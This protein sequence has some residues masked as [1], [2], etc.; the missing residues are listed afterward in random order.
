[1]AVQF[2]FQ[3]SVENLIMENE[4]I[5]EYVADDNHTFTIYL[6]DQRLQLSYFHEIDEEPVCI[7]IMWHSVRNLPAINYMGHDYF[8]IMNE[9]NIT[10][11]DVLTYT[12]LENCI[13][14]SDPRVPRSDD[15][16]QRLLQTPIQT[17]ADNGT[18]Q[19]DIFKNNSVHEANILP[20]LID[21]EAG[22]G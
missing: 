21:M 3:E 22:M 9:E 12:G 18:I 17:I 2:Q 6:L 11:K 10:L 5:E 20:P 14:Q 4:L 8:I 1:M 19:L 15:D 16:I 13:I 7:E